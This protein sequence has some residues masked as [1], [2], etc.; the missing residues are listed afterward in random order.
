MP[1][2]V[3]VPTRPFST[4]RRYSAYS[5]TWMLPPTRFGDAFARPG[6]VGRGA[7]H[8]DGR[9]DARLQFVQHRQQ[10]CTLPAA[11]WLMEKCLTQRTD[12]PG[13]RGRQRAGGVAQADCRLA[14]AA[15]RLVRG[16]GHVGHAGPGIRLH[17]I[18][19]PGRRPAAAWYRK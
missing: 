1:A 14:G 11:E 6:G 12:D 13:D 16:P 19:L 15:H 2:P 10:P 5:F 8:S 7:L 3:P 4:D 9:P 17:Q 18:R